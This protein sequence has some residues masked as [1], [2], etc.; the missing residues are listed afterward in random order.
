MKNIIRA[1]IN[2]TLLDKSAFFRGEKGVYADITLLENRDGIDQ[3]G[4]NFMVVQ[5]IGK[6]RREKG[7]KG[8]IIGNARYAGD[9]PQHAKAPPPANDDDVP[10]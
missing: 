6:E 1:K 7:D 9:K 2:V 10:W 3:Y 5:D 8:P 4:N